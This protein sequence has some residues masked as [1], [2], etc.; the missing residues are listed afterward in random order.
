[1]PKP[2]TS[3][4]E[5]KTAKTAAKANAP[6]AKNGQPKLAG[7]FV[8]YDVM[9]TDTKAAETFYKAVIGWTAADSGMP[10]QSYTLLSAG[11]TMVGGLMPI[12]EDARKVGVKPAW[13][14]YIGVDDVDVFAKK[15]TKAGGAIHKGPDDIPGVGRFAVAADPHGAGFVLFTPQTDQQPTPVAPGT[16]GQ[17]GWHEL[18]AGDGESAWAFYAGLFGWTK[19]MAV[20]MGPMG[21]YQTYATGGAPVGGMMTKPP[22]VPAPGWLY[23]FNVDSI[24][25]AI[26]RVKANG[27]EVLHGPMQVPGGSWIAQCRDPQGAM[28]AMVSCNKAT[29]GISALAPAPERQANYLDIFVVPVPKTNIEAYRSQAELF[30]KV[31]REHGALSCI[32]VEADDAPMGTVTSF[33]RSVALEPGETVFVGIMTFRDRSHRDEVNA[34]AMKD[35]RMASMDPKS[36]PFDG[37]RMF[38]GG[39]KPFVGG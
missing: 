13:M 24:E 2:K 16:P 19:D 28:F 8:W 18:Y 21:T 33:P 1:M 29:T 34:K 5:T 6:K 36:M 23:Y 37:R 27:G 31:W 11:A 30:F 26:A 4:P 7:R 20:D 12:P 38:F 25:A 15:V 9:T 39:F 3:K 32:E 35:P 10:G 22:H 17:I 14:G